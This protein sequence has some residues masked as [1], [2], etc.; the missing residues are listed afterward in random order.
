MRGSMF[1]VCEC[2]NHNSPSLH[3]SSPD[4]ECEAGCNRQRTQ[5]AAR[6]YE[7]FLLVRPCD[8]FFWIA[9]WTAW[10]R[11]HW[12]L[13]YKKSWRGWLPLHVDRSCNWFQLFEQSVDQ[14]AETNCMNGQREE[15]A[16]PASFSCMSGANAAGTMPS[17]SRS[18]RN[19]RTV[20]QAKKV[21]RRVPRLACV[22][23]YNRPRIQGQATTNAMTANC[24][25]SIHTHETLSP[26]FDFQRLRAEHFRRMESYKKTQLVLIFLVLCALMMSLIT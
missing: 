20:E 16:N 18:R 3:W 22:V 1:H 19:N 5:D 7:L 12:L 15:A 9:T 10:S 25:L 11:P 23:D 21:H 6:A 14:I 4:L 26:A 13:T 2:S 24:D 8:Y 17:M